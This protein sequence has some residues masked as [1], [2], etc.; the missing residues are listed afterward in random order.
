VGATLEDGPGV[1]RWAA[2]YPPLPFSPI[3]SL[4]LCLGLSLYIFYYY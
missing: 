3:V 4:L 2:F 1:G